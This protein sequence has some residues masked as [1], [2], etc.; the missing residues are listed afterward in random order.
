MYLHRHR[1]IY[2]IRY[3]TPSGE[4]KTVTTH[5]RNHRDAERFLRQY[6][7]EPELLEHK[8]T[9]SE[10][11]SSFLDWELDNHAATTVR[12]TRLTMNQFLP[13]KGNTAVAE[14][15]PADIEDYK[16]A[17]L[18]PTGK[19][20]NKDG[21][22][23]PKKGIARTTMNIE[24]RIL[25]MMFY[26]AINRLHVIDKNPVQRQLMKISDEEKRLPLDHHQFLA[27]YKALPLKWMRDF[28]LFA[29]LT[30]LRRREL[31]RLK[32]E[33]VYIAQ[34]RIYVIGKGNKAR[35]VALNRQAITVL[36]GITERY[37]YVFTTEKG[38]AKGK[39]V[40]LESATRI[41]VRA[42]GKAHL[43]GK[44]CLHSLRHS[45]AT[46]VLENGAQPQDVQKQM[47]HAYLE[48]T[49]GYTH[50]TDEAGQRAVAHMPRIKL[51]PS[52]PPL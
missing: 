10:L 15:T 42:R 28:V 37:E 17:R 11:A 23:V 25:K 14:F 8:F 3:R 13:L 12:I 26:H 2:Y 34:K 35:W 22:M 18:H 33:D 46:W 5:S 40:K 31:V 30:G 29:V 48:T 49:M 41:I 7:H 43:K 19:V 24:L 27:L 1:G 36:K 51:P 9:V 4:L 20:K 6:Q 50:L 45:F 21:E 44:I 47:G 39:P 16:R 52:K 32:W 38:D